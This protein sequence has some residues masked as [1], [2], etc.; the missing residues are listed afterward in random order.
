[1]KGIFRILRQGKNLN[2]RI[3]A[4]AISASGS[5]ALAAPKTR[6]SYQVIC[7]VMLLCVSCLTQAQSAIDGYTHRIRTASS[8][9]KLGPDLFGDATNMVDGSTTFSVTDVVVPT[10]S[11]LPLSIGRTFR[12]DAQIADQQGRTR[13]PNAVFGAYW[14]LDVPY[15][16]GTFDAVRGWVSA[17]QPGV[18]GATLSDTLKR[19]SEGGSGPPGTYGVGL[20]NLVF[21]HTNHFFSGINI[22]IPGSGTQEELIFPGNLINENIGGNTYYYK[23]KN[24]SLVGCLGSI[25]NG[26]GEGFI[27][28]LPDGRIYN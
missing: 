9:A 4:D 19:C 18:Q 12:V 13:A 11:G 5:E 21:Y 2:D 24:N 25:Q 26:T 1:M 17:A 28:K 14:D 10:N 22:N 16:V 15:M 6:L 23:T 7:M 3:E 8:I 20:F 27:V